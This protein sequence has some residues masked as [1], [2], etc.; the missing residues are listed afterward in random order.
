MLHALPPETHTVCRFALDGRVGSSAARALDR[1]LDLA[2]RTRGAV[3]VVLDVTGAEGV[4]PEAPPRP[5][6]VPGNVV[7]ATV[8][9]YGPWAA[10]AAARL[11]ALGCP[12]PRVF[13]PDV[14]DRAL[15]YARAFG[16]DA[17]GHRGS[18]SDPVLTEGSERTVPPE[19]TAAIRG[20][21]CPAAGTGPG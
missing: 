17:A 1:A 10:W 15:R 4:P 13:R 8:V 19:D 20:G 7:R 11:A 9:G 21:V 6:A 14:P 12:A 3:S 16:R 5:L 2:A 18:P